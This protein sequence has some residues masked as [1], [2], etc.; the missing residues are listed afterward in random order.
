MEWPFG[1]SNVDHGRN[2]V[3]RQFTWFP[4]S[5]L[6]FAGLIWRSR[7]I[8]NGYRRVNCYC[9]HLMQYPDG[10]PHQALQ[11]LVPW[12]ETHHVI[13]WGAMWR[14]GWCIFLN[15]E[16]IQHVESSKSQGSYGNGRVLL[17]YVFV[18]TTRWSSRVESH[19]CLVNL[20]VET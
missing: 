1:W 9:K 2:A 19:S 18:P 5:S 16:L 7:V 13:L 4:L 10:Q 12:V 14:Q 8:S 20:M 17:V 11:W 3:N 6:M 15:E